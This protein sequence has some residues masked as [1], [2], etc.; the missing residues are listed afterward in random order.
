[1]CTLARLALSVSA[2]AIL[3]AATAASAGERQAPAAIAPGGDAQVRAAFDQ[4]AKQWMAK[5]EKSAVPSKDGGRREYAD[6]SIELRPTGQSSAPYVGLLRYTENVVE[7]AAPGQCATTASIPV[8]EIFR[9]E[10]GRW[11]Y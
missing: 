6:Y 4:F 11:V 2:T 5:V 9:F 3:F 1:M 7:C 8:T 10:R